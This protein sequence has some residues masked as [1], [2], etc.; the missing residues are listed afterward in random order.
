MNLRRY[1]YVAM[2][3]A[4][5][6]CLSGQAFSQILR[7]QNTHVIGFFA[8][9]AQGRQDANV[10][11]RTTFTFSN[12]HTENPVSG[13]LYFADDEGQFMPLNFGSG[14]VDQ[15]PITIPPL[16]ST[17]LTGVADGSAL[18]VGWAWAEFDIPVHGVATYGLV[19]QSQALS[20]VSVPASLPTK[21]YFSAATATLGIAL[22]N[23]EGSSSSVTITANG[24]DGSEQAVTRTIPPWGHE[25][26]F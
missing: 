8:Q 23:A 4:L 3:V 7:S 11:W 25:A 2:I 16:G 15:I 5:A 13:T 12:P 19:S 24:N 22:V 14:P 20:E 9:I 21:A 18:K 6:T 10:E 17:T 26:F 1:S